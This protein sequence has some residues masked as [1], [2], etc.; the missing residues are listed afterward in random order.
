MIKP[1]MVM[2]TWNLGA[3]EAEAGGSLELTEQLVSKVLVQ[4]VT[5]GEKK[6]GAIQEGHDVNLNTQV[7]VLTTPTPSYTDFSLKG[8]L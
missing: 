2:C 1:G 7:F 3:G 6:V 4:R 5:L 8:D